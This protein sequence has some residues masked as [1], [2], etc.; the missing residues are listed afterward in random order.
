M[1]ALLH[2]AVCSRVAGCEE[3]KNAERLSVG[4]R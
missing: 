3:T 4:P 2:Q 1:I